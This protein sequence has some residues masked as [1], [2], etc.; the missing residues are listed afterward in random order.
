MMSD[1][2]GNAQMDVPQALESSASRNNAAG[3]QHMSTAGVP[4]MEAAAQD[5]DAGDGLG[6]PMP[7]ELLM[8]LLSGEQPALRRLDGRQHAY[9]QQLTTNAVLSAT[10]TASRALAG[11]C[12]RRAG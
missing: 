10:M 3:R 8:P 1:S 6:R 12:G 5:H 2:H 9:V 4:Q 7:G 11:K